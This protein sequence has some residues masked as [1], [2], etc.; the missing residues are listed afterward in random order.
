MSVKI[1]NSDLYAKVK[2]YL[3]VSLI[4]RGTIMSTALEERQLITEENIPKLI[5]LLTGF[6]V[7]LHEKRR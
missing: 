6:N 3:F 5:K 7:R 2:A 4:V 1:E